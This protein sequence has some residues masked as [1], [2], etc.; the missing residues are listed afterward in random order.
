MKKKREFEPNPET[1]LDN[2]DENVDPAQMSGD[3]WVEEEN[4]PLQEFFDTKDC[5]V[6]EEKMSDPAAMFQHPSINV[7]YGNDS[8]TGTAPKDSREKRK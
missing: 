5:N 2:W 8:F 3:H 7:T 1:P 6:V 4:A